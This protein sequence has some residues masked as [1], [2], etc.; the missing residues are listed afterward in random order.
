MSAP[1]LL[2]KN[3]TEI[4]NLKERREMLKIRLMGTIQEIR[5]FEKLL[6]KSTNLDVTEFSKPF[7]NKGTNNA[8]FMPKWNAQIMDKHKRRIRNLWKTQRQER[9]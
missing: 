4:K 8:E 3:R 9:K 7:H 5:W 6:H 2:T 1:F